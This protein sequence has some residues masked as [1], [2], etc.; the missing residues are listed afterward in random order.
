MLVNFLAPPGGF[1]FKIA[2]DEHYARFSPG[3]LIQIENLQL[4]ER[5]DIAW[6]D[7]CAIENHP[8]INSL[9]TERRSIVRVTIP[10]AGRGR[11]LVH[12]AARTLETASAAVRRRLA[13]PGKET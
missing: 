12:A 13:S 7:S 1:T 2:F 4:L 5:A 9:W 8:M 3:V 10:R 11:R 6:T